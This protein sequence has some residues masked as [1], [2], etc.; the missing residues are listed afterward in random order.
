MEGHRELLVVEGG[1]IFVIGE[2]SWWLSRFGALWSAVQ[3]W[4]RVVGGW[5]RYWRV[6]VGALMVMC[7]VGKARM[8]YRKAQG[9]R[10]PTQTRPDTLHIVHR[11]LCTLHRTTYFALYTVH[12]TH[13]I[14]HTVHSAQCICSMCCNIDETLETWLPDKRAERKQI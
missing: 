7:R 10:V 5:W 3:G 12:S 1:K 6:G 14:Q 13:C 4:R 2:R 9:L 8:A 11:A